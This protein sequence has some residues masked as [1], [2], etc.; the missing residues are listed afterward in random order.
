MQVRSAQV[1]IFS[2]NGGWL[3]E[4]L[5][6]R[7]HSLN[8]AYALRNRTFSGSDTGPKKPDWRRHILN[9]AAHK[10]ALKHENPNGGQ[11]CYNIYYSP[12]MFSLIII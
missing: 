12:S 6:V 10:D 7:H 8:A 3:Q 4:I 5:A 1:T 9:R 11:A 2:W